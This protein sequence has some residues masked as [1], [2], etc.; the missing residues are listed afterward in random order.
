VRAGRWLR[1]AYPWYVERLGGGRAL[2]AAL[3]ATDTVEA[4]RTVLAAQRHAHG[5]RH[6]I[7]GGVDGAHAHD[8]LQRARAA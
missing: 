4:A 1:K 7:A 3:Q 5:A 6:R 8:E 2:Q